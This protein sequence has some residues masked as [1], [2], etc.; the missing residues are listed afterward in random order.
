MFSFFYKI[1]RPLN[2]LIFIALH[3][4]YAQDPKLEKL[5]FDVDK[6]INESIADSAVS[7]TH[8]TLPTNGEV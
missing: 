3:S 8:L 2:I 7:Y 1:F 6:L 5:S 4:N